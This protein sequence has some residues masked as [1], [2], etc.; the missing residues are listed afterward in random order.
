MNVWPPHML[1]ACTCAYCASWSCVEL[2]LSPLSSAPLMQVLWSVSQIITECWHPNPEVRL[3]ALRVKKNLNK[4]ISNSNEKA[5]SVNWEFSETRWIQFYFYLCL[6]LS[7]VHSSVA[8]FPQI[9][10]LYIMHHMYNVP[11]YNS[12]IHVTSSLRN[13]YSVHNLIILLQ[14]SSIRL[15]TCIEI[16]NGL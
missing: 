8:P 13:L 2:K 11:K 9:P 6:M 4:A 5:Q 1:Y 12:S 14:Q 3:T 7:L 10:A 15:Y 16:Q